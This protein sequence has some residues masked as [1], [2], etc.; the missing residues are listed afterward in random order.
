MY[1]KIIL[2]ICCRQENRYYRGPAKG[3]WKKTVQE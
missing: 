3:G 2:L 1:H